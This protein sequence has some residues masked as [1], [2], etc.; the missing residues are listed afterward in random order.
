MSTSNYIECPKC[1]KKYHVKSGPGCPFCG[2]N[3]ENYKSFGS[4]ITKRLA[5]FVK[6]KPA[7]SNNQKLDEGFNFPEFPY[8]EDTIVKIKDRTKYKTEFLADHYGEN[9]GP[10]DFKCDLAPYRLEIEVEEIKVIIKKKTTTFLMMEK[11]PSGFLN[12][13]QTLIYNE[14]YE[15]QDDVEH[16][17]I[18]NPTTIKLQK[19]GFIT[20]HEIERTDKNI[21]DYLSGLLV[22]DLKKQCEKFGLKR[23]QNKQRLI[24]SL[25]TVKEKITIPDIAVPTQK[26]NDLIDTL[27]QAYIADLEEQLSDKPTEYSAAAWNFVAGDCIELMLENGQKWVKEKEEKYHHLFDE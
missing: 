27:S 9:Y 20:G 1:K 17:M 2:T 16:Q 19:M 3:P 5:D 21:S 26:Y 6:V 8:A 15:S 14:E 13:H 10:E 24:Q 7:P 12:F 18:D 4:Q 22:A 11:L 23:T 25:M